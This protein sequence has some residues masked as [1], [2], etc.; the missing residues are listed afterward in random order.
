MTIPSSFFRGK[1]KAHFTHPLRPYLSSTSTKSEGTEERRGG[2]EHSL[3]LQPRARQECGPQMPLSK[4]QLI[5]C[6]LSEPFFPNQLP[7]DT[8]ATRH[9]V[10]LYTCRDFF[11]E[12]HHPCKGTKGTIHLTQHLP[13]VFSHEHLFTSWVL[14]NRLGHSAALQSRMK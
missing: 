6:L 7:L 2:T 11:S 9:P 1:A 4:Q 10:F 12:L 5:R 14:Q 3:C 13:S 8:R